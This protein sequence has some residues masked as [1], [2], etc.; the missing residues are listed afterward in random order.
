MGLASKLAAAGAAGGP[1][2]SAA[3]SN[4]SAPASGYGASHPLPQTPQSYGAPPAYQSGGQPQNSQYAPPTGPPP[5]LTPGG[6][7]PQS[8]QYAPPPGPPP[9]VGGAGAYGQAPQQHSYGQQQQGYGQQPG[10]YGQQGSY[11]Q[12]A[13]GQQQQQQQYGAP[14]GPPPPPARPQQQQQSAAGGSSATDPNFIFELLKHTVVDQHIEAFYP[15]PNQLYGLA[16][17]IARDG[18]L[19]RVANEWRMPL[20]IGMDLAKLALFDTILYCD[21]SGSMAFEEGGSRI[22]DLKLIVSRVAFAASL[23]DDDGIEVRFMNS[24]IEGNGLKTEAEAN[25]LVGQVRFSGLTPLGTALQSKVLEPLVLGPA[26][27][28]RLKKPVLI[29]AV[30]DGIPGGEARETLTNVIINAN[31]VLRQTRYGPDAVSYQLAQVGN[32]QKA[33]AFLEEID[34]HPVVG[35]LVDCT[36]NYEN[37]Q[38]DMA[39]GNPPVDLTPELWLVKMLLGGIDSS[40]D[41]TDEK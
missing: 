17:R 2:S 25:N 37:E 15:D 9:P 1:T 30:T 23:F 20:E 6:N 18:A 26:R 13:Y 22:D 7:R 8:G 35:D 39:K 4:T 29:I 40:Y 36:S 31:N 19:A 34:N 28:G 21:D 27:A 16:Q 5:S 12:P 41:K 32:D 38:D 33:R 10:A 14:S 24:R 11:G 3:P